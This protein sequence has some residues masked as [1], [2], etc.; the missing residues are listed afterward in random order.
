M[1]SYSTPDSDQ[2]NHQY[3][4]TG[5]VDTFT[6]PY[7]NK[8]SINIS[9]KTVNYIIDSRDRNKQLY[10]SPSNYEVDLSEEYRDVKEIE[11]LSVQ[12]PKITYTIN[13]NNDQFKLYFGDTAASF[14]L[15]HGHFKE[16]CNLAR[17][18][19][20][21]INNNS[22]HN[23]PNIK[24][25]YIEHLHKLIFQSPHL[26]CNG[27]VNVK[28]FLT[29]DFEGNKCCF[30]DGTRFETEYPKS[31]SGEVLGFNAGVY[32][33][34]CG[35]IF[36]NPVDSQDNFI[37]D[38]KT[39]SDLDT[40]TP[41]NNGVCEDSNC[42]RFVVRGDS[43]KLSDYILRPYS[44]DCLTCQVEYIYLRNH[45]SAF[46]PAKVISKYRCKPRRGTVN[47]IDTDSWIVE[48]DKYWGITHG[49]FELFCDYI[50][51]E[52]LVDL[53]PHK[54]VLLKIPRC[55]RFQS[56]DKDTQKSFAKIPLQSGE[57]H[58][59]NLNAPGNIKGF[60]PPLAMLDKLQ[61]QWL[62]YNNGPDNL[63]GQY[64]DFAGGEHVIELAIVYYRQPLKYS[65]IS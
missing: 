44:S 22:P 63:G 34:Y 57:Y 27:E 8:E 49:H 51:S 45:K 47:K 33:M 64:F 29:L 53:A 35:K 15:I 21:S 4:I 2:D 28:G 14:P 37:L 61:I 50:V 3:P 59:S 54:Y 32:D 41:E 56:I 58:I 11:L 39:L 52:K 5:I 42:T 60:N 19:E 55:H 46:I 16:G 18:I 9:T 62:K 7:T 26:Q 20:T 48:I 13:K 25:E 23:T 10:P 31:S 43:I 12:L 30:G 1:N 38:D 36:I 65:Q 24:V 40:E 6:K 17:A